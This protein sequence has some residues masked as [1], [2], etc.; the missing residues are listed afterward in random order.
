MPVALPANCANVFA[1]AG[2]DALNNQAPYSNSGPENF[3]AAP[4][5]DGSKSTTGSGLPDGIYSATASID[6]AGNRLPTYG[7]LQGTSMAAP[8]VSGVLA[9]M[10][11]ANPSLTPQAIEQMVRNGSIVDDIGAPGW[12]G[13]FG[14][15][16]VNARKAVDAALAGNGGKGPPAAGQTQAQPGTI[17][18]G[19]L[20]TEAD[21]ELSHVGS[22][23]ERVVSVTTNSPVITVEPK[24]AAVD[25]ATGLGVYRVRANRAAMAV[26][27]AAFPSVVV[28]LTPARTLTVQVAIE[29]RAIALGQGNLGPA[30]L[31]VLDAEDPAGTV[32][33]TE[34]VSRPVGGLYPYTVTIPG[35]AAVSF[36]AGS[37]LDN[38]GMICSAGEACGGYPMLSGQLEVLRPAG[39]LTGIDFTLAPYGGISPDA[40]DARR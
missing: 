22:S 10:R 18:L 17:S 40:V 21:L 38:N 1:V 14:Y 11:W 36:I 23:N 16:L 4:G 15:G 32:V 5:G 13:T 27:S 28:Q 24:A 26:G 6:G 8:H 29:R 35:T 31:L 33:A 12:D 9:L 37:D 30:Y 7:F 3:I 25:S 2:T 20:R 19:S 39:N 34:I